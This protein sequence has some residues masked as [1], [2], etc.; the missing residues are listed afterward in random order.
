MFCIKCGKV[1]DA[2]AKVCPD[3]G[4]KVVLPDGFEAESSTVKTDADML[5]GEKTV[6]ADHNAIAKKAAAAANAE[7]TVSAP[8]PAPV[9]DSAVP[10]APAGFD[11]DKAKKIMNGRSILI[12]DSPLPDAMPVATTPAVAS[13]PAASL[14]AEKRDEPVSADK[15]TKLIVLIAAIVAVAAVIGVVLAV[16]L[17][18]RNNGEDSAKENT[19]GTTVAETA[20]EE[21][22]THAMANIG[23]NIPSLP[24]GQEETESRTGENITG[25]IGNKPIPTL[26]DILK[27]EKPSDSDEEDDEI[28][29]HRESLTEAVVDPS[30][31]ETAG[32]IDHTGIPLSDAVTELPISENVVVTAN[33]Q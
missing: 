2:S 27:P 25:E 20:A 10:H 16:A 7:V 14:V 26:P 17:S 13:A 31:D 8:V 3:C 23:E 15:K 12:D 9:A 4:T 6:S 30:E 19:S 1:L 11:L 24:L 28:T 29:T 18:G 5:S 32:V 33:E 21:S 22:T